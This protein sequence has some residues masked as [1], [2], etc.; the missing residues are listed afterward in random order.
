MEPLGLIAGKGSLPRVVCETAKLRGIP[1]IAVAFSAESA[2]TLDGLAD[3]QVL[4][5]GQAGKIIRRF[6]DAGCHN[7]CLIGKVDKKTVFEKIALDIRG[8]KIM[9]RL[10]KKD[11]GS[12]MRAIIEEMEREGLNVEKQ[13]DWLPPLLP[14]RG[15]LGK[16]KPSKQARADMEYG[17]GI[18]KEMAD[19]EIGQTV[20]VKDRVVLAVEAVEGT[21]AAI[22][23][24]CALGGKGAVMAKTSRPQQDLRFDIPAVGPST[25]KLLAKHGAA[26]LA[27]EAERVVVV[28]LPEVIAICDKAGI[29]LA[30]L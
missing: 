4:G 30:A 19:K 3:V 7:V 6:K 25:A 28:D 17:I 23:R 2:K 21:D 24:G 29:A 13:T 26:G 9:G 10:L 27:V 14:L 5:V 15:I 18:C 8:M 11:D 12:I 22:E 20:L 16:V 1:V